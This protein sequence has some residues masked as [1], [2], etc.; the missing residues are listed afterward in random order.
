MIRRVAYLGMHTSPL[1][2]PGLGDAGGLNVY[3]HELACTMAKRGIEVVVF[4]RRT[5]SRQDDVVDPAPGYRVVHVTAGPTAPIPVADMPPHITSFANGVLD[6]TA[7]AGVTF[8][9]VHS[10]YWLSGW[11]GVLV[12]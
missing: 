2:Q 6:W 8:D 10:H 11:S 4:T 12:K 7:D 3:M 9:L 5:D 1:V